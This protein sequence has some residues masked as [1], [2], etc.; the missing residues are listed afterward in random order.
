[1]DRP[2]YNVKNISNKVDHQKIC[3]W[4]SRGSQQNRQSIDCCMLAPVH[5]GKLFSVDLQ[6]KRR[7]RRKI[8]VLT[9]KE[10]RQ[11]RAAAGMGQAPHR[12]RTPSHD[13]TVRA[14]KF[15]KN[16]SESD[17]HACMDWMCS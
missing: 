2:N 17:L 11:V 1:M 7:S 8:N 12:Q 3:R 15:P 9:V 4:C 5:V 16:E 10:R 6:S 14:E 13:V